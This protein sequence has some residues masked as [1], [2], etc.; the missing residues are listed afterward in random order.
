MA[1]TAV[2]RKHFY[3]G[4]TVLTV[5]DPVLNEAAASFLDAGAMADRTREEVQEFVRTTFRD[6]RPRVPALTVRTV[7]GRPAEEIMRVAHEE[8]VDAIV[9]STHGATGLQ[10][11]LFG[12]KTERVL[13][14]TDVPVIVTPAADQGP[15]SLEAWQS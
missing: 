7:I 9:M 5:D 6:R 2:D 13:R 8:H 14:Q 10:K 11:V 15:E 1:T 3:A 12:S 4:L